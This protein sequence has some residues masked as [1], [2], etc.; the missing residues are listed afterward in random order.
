MIPPFRRADRLIA[1]TAHFPLCPPALERRHGDLYCWGEQVATVLGVM[2][3][4]PGCEL[5]DVLRDEPDSELGV[6]LSI[7]KGNRG[8]TASECSDRTG[9]MGSD[10]AKPPLSGWRYCSCSFV[11]TI[12]GCCLRSSFSRL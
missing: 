9:R 8:D 11:A 10:M 4:D 2:V 6:F 12:A 7:F 5:S 1:G 3:A